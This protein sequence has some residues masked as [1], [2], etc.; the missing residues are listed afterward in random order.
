MKRLPIA[1]TFTVALLAMA[2]LAV[3]AIGAPRNPAAL[4]KLPYSGGMLMARAVAAGRVLLPS[5]HFA[6]TSIA[7]V[8]TCSPAPCKLPN[9]DASEGG[10]NPVNEDPIAANPTNTSQWITGGNDYNC[11]SIQG[12]FATSDNGATITRNCL[13]TLSGMVGAGDPIVAYDTNNNVY[14]GG[15]D[16]DSSFTTGQIVISQSTN[17]GVT[18]P[19]PHV[20]VNSTFSGGLTDKPWME[21][22]NNP[23][24]PHKGSIYISITDFSSTSSSQ[25]TVSHSTDGGATFHTVKVSGTEN[26]PAVN[27]FSDLAVGKDGTVYLS[28]IDCPGTGPT[29]D[30][31]RDHDKDHV[32]EVKRWRRNMVDSCS[33]DQH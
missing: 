4:E 21:A 12:F 13:A 30:C 33:G 19:A 3:V 7:P 25:I 16:T 27:Q 2:G 26:I 6:S 29:G 5:S 14:A 11:G 24:S 10:S 8:L 32:F 31:G 20:A 22:D 17:G 18:F 28:W 23:T 1:V 9:I 15:I